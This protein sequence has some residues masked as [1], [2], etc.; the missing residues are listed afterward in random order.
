MAAGTDLRRRVVIGRVSGL[1]GV[2][3]W[4]K[5]F[6]HTRPADNLLGFREVELKV[7]GAWEPFRLAEGRRQGRTLVARFEG[8]DDRDAAAALVG[9]E[10]AC[11]RE[12]LPETGEDEYYWDD[13]VGLEVVNRDGTEFGRVDRMMETGAHDVMVVSGDR[14]RLIPFTP[15]MHVVEVDLDHGRIVVDWDPAF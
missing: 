8:I 2:R 5:L 9:A 4:V 3:G 11:R 14:E 13:L 10:L 12:S 15:G 1:F 7:G 6:S